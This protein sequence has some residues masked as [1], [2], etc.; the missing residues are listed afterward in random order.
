MNAEQLEALAVRCE[1][2]TGPDNEL[3]RSIARTRGWQHFFV[4]KDIW[5]RAP[6]GVT[7]GDVPR[8]TGSLDAA[9]TLVPDGW[10]WL[11]R[12]DE[13]QRAF[14][15]LTKDFQAVM[16]IAGGETFDESTGQ[17]FPAYAATASLALCAA[18]LRALAAKVP[19]TSHISQGSP[20]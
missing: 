20:E 18:S 7:H 8:F 19:N 5:W 6:S 14:A 3:D 1:Q 10:D 11:T 13:G 2:A 12:N 16:V 9:V 4:Q 15:N 17:S